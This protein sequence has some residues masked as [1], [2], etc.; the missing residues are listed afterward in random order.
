M[1][2]KARAPLDSP[3]SEQKAAPP[4]NPISASGH[5]GRTFA[6]IS[7]DRDNDND[8]IVHAFSKRSLYVVASPFMRLSVVCLSVCNVRAPYSGD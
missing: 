2:T 8:C 1:S 7:A 3:D 6:E 5:S 4:P